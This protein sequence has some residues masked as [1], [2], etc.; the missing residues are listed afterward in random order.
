MMLCENTAGGKFIHD[1][2]FGEMGYTITTERNELENQH[3]QE[4]NYGR[5]S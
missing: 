1:V 5:W 3:F 2:F 4:V